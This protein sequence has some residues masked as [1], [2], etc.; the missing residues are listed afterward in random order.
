MDSQELRKASGGA[1]EFARRIRE[2]RDDE[3]WPILTNN[4]RRDLKPG[5][6]LMVEDPPWEAAIVFARAISKKLRAQIL[7][8]NGSTCQMCGLTPDEIDPLTGRKT[9]LHIGHI[10]DKSLGG[11]NELSNLRTLCSACNQGAKNITTEKPS[12]IWLKSQVRRAG[13]DDQKVILDWLRRKFGE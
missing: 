2:L 11:K 3:G 8:R 4:D 6:Y 9:R 5:Q 13:L 10:K 12:A 1:S 7:D